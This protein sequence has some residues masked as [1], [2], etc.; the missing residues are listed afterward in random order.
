MFLVGSLCSWLCCVLSCVDSGFQQ[1]L[2][3][4]LVVTLAFPFKVATAVV[5]ARISVVLSS[6]ALDTPLVGACR[7]PKALRLSWA[8]PSVGTSPVLLGAGPLLCSPW[9]RAALV[10]GLSAGEG[11]TRFRP[12]LSPSPGRLGPPGGLGS[13][14]EA[15]GMMRC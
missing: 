8:D 14:G 4:L 13:L 5:P 3:A 7:S 9:S 11:A 6:R 12:H 2:L 1:V 15:P 10:L